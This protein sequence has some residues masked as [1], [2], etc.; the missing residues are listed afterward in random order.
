MSHHVGLAGVQIQIPDRVPKMPFRLNAFGVESIFH[1]LAISE[2][3][4][5]IDKPGDQGIHDL[6]ERRETLFPFQ[7]THQMNMVDH[8]GI[9]VD[10]DVVPVFV[11]HEE[12]IELL[13]DLI[14]LQQGMAAVA[15]PG[16][17]EEIVVTDDLIPWDSHTRLVS[18]IRANRESNKN[19]T[20]RY[21]SIE[22]CTEN[23]T[24]C[25]ENE[26]TL[27]RTV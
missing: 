14:V 7:S 25:I 17:M 19:K 18:K 8:E 24:K 6:K 4:S 11:L 5:S 9:G 13:F 10:R 23:G 20:F 15:P 27:D 12:I 22:T 3:I 1:H 16:H 2:G 21:S 26:T